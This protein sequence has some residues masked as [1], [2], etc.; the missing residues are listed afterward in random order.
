MTNPAEQ[1]ALPPGHA[2][3][4]REIEEW[5][6]LYFTRPLGAALTSAAAALRLT[7]TQVTIIGIVVGVAGGALLYDPRFG[8]V[9][10]GLLFLHAILD[11]ADGQ[12]ARKTG[13]ASELGRVLD[14]VAGYLTHM[15][16]F[17]AIAAGHLQRGG[18]KS[19]LI[20]MLLA[21]LAA[22]VHAQAYDYYRTGYA[23]VVSERRARRSEPAQVRGWLRGPYRA[24]SA[25]QRVVVASHEEVGAALNSRAIGGII[26]EDDRD[27]Y[28]ASFHRLVR[29]WNLLGDNM[30][31]YAVGVLVCV[32]R[33]DLL[34]AYIAVVMTLIFLVM[35]GWQARAD[36]R[37]LERLPKA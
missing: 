5:T 25:I 18:S 11:S 4:P 36:R 33:I 28:R 29:G 19:I 21:G 22:I 10:F 26:R 3:K 8:F 14:G 31:R 37:F 30:R 23:S 24:Y 27:R 17:I 7:P 32:G 9:A 15:A 34:F 1:A 16:M 13:Q 35:R 6:D 2:G 12:L 20:W